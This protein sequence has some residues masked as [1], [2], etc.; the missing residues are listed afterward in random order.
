MSK[1]EYQANIELH[2]MHK[3]QGYA[4]QMFNTTG[5]QAREVLR[6][7]NARNAKGF[8]KWVAMIAVFFKG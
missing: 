7:H 1:S 2:Q 3:N 8:S 4:R 6:N 5:D